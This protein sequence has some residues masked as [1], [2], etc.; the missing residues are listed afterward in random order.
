M[1]T[2]TMQMFA[3]ALVDRPGGA[4]EV[5]ILRTQASFTTPVMSAR[6]SPAVMSASP[7]CPRSTSTTVGSINVLDLP[8]LKGMTQ[9]ERS[10][11]LDGP[12]GAQLGSMLEEKMGVEVPGNWP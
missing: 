9:M 4:L 11:M 7:T 1:A 3:D 5:E 12:L 6:P 10:E 8:M 2:R